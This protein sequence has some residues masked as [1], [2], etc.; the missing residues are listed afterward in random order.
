MRSLLDQRS[1]SGRHAR[2]QDGTL[3]KASLALRGLEAEVVTVMRM[4]HL[5]LAACGQRKS[6]GRRFMSLDF[7]HGFFSF[8]LTKRCRS[9]FVFNG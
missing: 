8:F 3:T 6:L 7:S 5:D 9:L 2:V 1:D 4:I